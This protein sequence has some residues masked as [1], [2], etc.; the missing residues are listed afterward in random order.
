MQVSFFIASKAA[1]SHSRET[2]A[3]AFMTMHESCSCSQ[4][5]LFAATSIWAL[6]LTNRASLTCFDTQ[7]SSCKGP[8][9][10]P[11]SWHADA[12]DKQAVGWGGQN[13]SDSPQSPMTP[14]AAKHCRSPRYA[15]FFC[16]ALEQDILHLHHPSRQERQSPDW[17]IPGL[18]C[19]IMGL[20]L[21]ECLSSFC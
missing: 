21:Q 10:Q 9:R 3:Q 20:E 13:F 12:H 18:A 1:G 15:C 6:L 11:G 14:N 16:F 8:F 17:A 19:Q 5:R 7:E 2:W 4:I